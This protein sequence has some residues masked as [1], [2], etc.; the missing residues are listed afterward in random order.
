MVDLRD[1]RNHDDIVARIRQRA[2]ATEPG[3][4]IVCTPVGEPFYY[5][6]RSHLDLDERRLPDRWILDKATD[7]HPV[8]IMAMSPKMPNVCAFNSL[9][10]RSVGIGDAVPPRVGNVWIEKDDDSGVPTG[11]LHGQVLDY[12]NPDPFWNQIRQALP[13][14]PS[15]FWLEGAR[16]GI[17][18][19]HR[20]G[21]TSIYEGHLM[22]VDHIEA[23]A[24][25]RDRG[26]LTMRVMTALELSNRPLFTQADAGAAMADPIQECLH[27]ALRL[28]REIPADDFLRV[29]GVTLGRSGST[30][31]GMART[32]DLY[33]PPFA[34]PT[35]GKC[36]LPRSVE[37]KAIR[38]CLENDLRLNLTL[39][40]PKD[41]DD[42]FKSL[43][44]YVDT[45]DI[46]SRGWIIQHSP[47]ITPAQVRQHAE[48][49]TRFTM[50]TSFTWGKAH[51]WSSCMGQH[52]LKD[53]NPL[54]RMIDAGIPVGNGTDWG[55]HN[56]FEHLVL[57]E[58]H[59]LGQTGYRNNGA[60]QLLTR[61]Q[62]LMMWT[63][64][65][66]RSL[67]WSGVGTLEPGHH[68]DLIVLDRNPL[69]ASLGELPATRV[70][71]TLVGGRTVHD[72]GDL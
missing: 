40:T 2:A 49:G 41:H 14:P 22:A 9:G 16:H 53:F 25:L 68:A 1:A 59:E 47:L 63:R 26:E 36:L 57:S 17:P 19:Y 72:S 8:F 31:A 35:F 12:L 46:R 30:S 42:F 34:E 20:M 51:I 60:D 10:L 45:H 55:P 48:I 64:D 37:E 33:S 56:I 50:S 6:R 21:V 62:A 71:R 15:D 54:K 13:A 29:D 4:W 61:E 3:Q 43:A 52:V 18:V 28:A 70:L 66:S 69:T 58:T 44:P 24:T 5:F 23:Y 38:F 11:V 27:Q 32:Y 65:A 39:L 67:S 7:R